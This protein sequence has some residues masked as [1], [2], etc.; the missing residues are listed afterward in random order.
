MSD[1]ANTTMLLEN[2]KKVETD[3][4][5]P[6]VAFPIGLIVGTAVTKA[7]WS[8]FE[9]QLPTAWDKT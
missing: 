7:T 2:I 9:Q 4:F 5:P 3:N 1:D 8:L 6:P